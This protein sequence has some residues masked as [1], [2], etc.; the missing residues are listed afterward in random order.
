MYRLRQSPASVAASTAD[1]AFALASHGLWS[2]Y[3]SVLASV[4]EGGAVTAPV[5]SALSSAAMALLQL[6]ATTGAMLPLVH[7][8]GALAS[9]PSLAHRQLTFEREAAYVVYYLVA[10]LRQWRSTLED[11]EVAELSGQAAAHFGADGAS[12]DARFSGE[13]SQAVAV[14]ADGKS[15]KSSSAGNSFAVLGTPVSEVTRGT[16]CVPPSC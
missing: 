10:Q 4:P 2:S 11:L 5:A 8:C 13:A 7:A 6:A 15:V 12:I 16:T 9:L 14:S 3:A 1:E